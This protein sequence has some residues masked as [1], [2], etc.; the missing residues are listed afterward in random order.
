MVVL[1]VAVYASTLTAGFTY[2]DVQTIRG[3]VGVHGPFS[4]RDIFLRDWWGLPFEKTVGSYRPIPTLTFWLDWHLAGGRPWVFHL[5]NLVLYGALLLT[6]NTFLARW[7]ADVLGPRAR[8]LT[9]AAF[10]AMAIHV[11]VV[12]SAT[13]RAELLATLFILLATIVAVPRSKK[14]PWWAVVASPALVGLALLSKESTF[15]MA[16]VVPFLVARHHRAQRTLELP[17]LAT[18]ATVCTAALAAALWF[19]MGRLPLAKSQFEMLPDNFLT[20][21]PWWRQKLGAFEVLTHYL[22]HTLTGLDLVPD[23]SYSAI[24]VRTSGLSA[25]AFVGFACYAGLGWLI[26]RGIRRDSKLAD[27]A[28]AFLGSFLVASHLIVPA[29]AMVADRLF[30]FPSFW[31]AVIAGLALDRL[32]AVAATARK[33]RLGPRK[34]AAI[35]TVGL[36][37]TQGSLAAAAATNWS[38]DATLCTQALQ[39]Q[40]HVAR[41]RENLSRV[42]SIG[43]KHDEAAW[44]ALLANAYFTRF[45]DPIPESDFP[46]AWDDLPMNVRLAE[47]R[48]TL[49]DRIYAQV[50]RNTQRSCAE[51]RQVESVPILEKWLL[52][53]PPALRPPPAEAEGSAGPTH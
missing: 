26:A 21:L 44:H 1:G 14:L 4:L 23:Y 40:P 34:L 6:A 38:D 9:I 11:D 12:P 30:F 25:R 36:S 8:L 16:L 10:A 3:H 43:G 48:R 7:A 49:G 29:S 33:G 18:L 42:L 31:L 41:I 27:A 32:P 13:G 28:V 24:L 51:A 45:P 20:A 37:L 50:L 47:L 53:L 46:L 5:T 15:P 35:G 39:A 52:Q 22:E 19:R 2:D 17:K